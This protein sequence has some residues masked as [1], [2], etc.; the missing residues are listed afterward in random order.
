MNTADASGRQSA[1]TKRWGVFAILLALT[2]IGLGTA[3]TIALTQGVGDN[4]VDRAKS[5]VDP[6]TSRDLDREQVLGIARDFVQKFNTYGPDLLDEDGHMPA[7]AG[8]SEQMTAKFSGVFDSNVGYAEQTVEQLS[9][10][11]RASVYAVAIASEDADSAEVLVAGTANFSYPNPKDEK[12]WIEFDPQRFR[13]QVSL[14]KQH[15]A[16]LIDDLDDVDD[17]LPSFA[18]A[19]GTKDGGGLP[20]MPG[21]PTDLPSDKSEGAQR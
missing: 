17:D 18:E 9:V 4:P 12:K 20:G 16:W 7:Y 11:R 8:L 6:P 2:V 19:N 10:R 13:Y 14:V 1:L 15:G 21:D 5:L 3:G